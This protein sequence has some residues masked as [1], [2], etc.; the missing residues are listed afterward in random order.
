MF[1]RKAI[2]YGVKSSTIFIE[3]IEIRIFYMVI[4]GGGSNF[5]EDFTIFFNKGAVI[6]TGQPPILS[7]LHIIDK[8]NNFSVLSRH[9]V[10]IFAKLCTLF[11]NRGNI[12]QL[13]KL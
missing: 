2:F 12:V 3:P 11:K 5:T 6:V 8:T 4:K 1:M 10:Y 7:K 13:W 9:I